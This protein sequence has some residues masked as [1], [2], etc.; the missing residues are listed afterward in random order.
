LLARE[1]LNNAVKHG[2]GGDA[3]KRVAL[4]LRFSKQQIRL[5]V[6]DQ[7]QGFDWKRALAAAPPRR[8]KESG[9]GLK[10][11][12]WY[13][14]RVRFNARGNEITLWLRGADGH[15]PKSNYA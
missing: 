3:S 11:I 14:E 12:R 7:G 13:A 6:A 8:N 4:S 5:R 15:N 10:I 1:C 9:R 2:N